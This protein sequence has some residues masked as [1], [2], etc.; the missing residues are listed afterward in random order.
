M[1]NVWLVAFVARVFVFVQ[2]SGGWTPARGVA[3]LKGYLLPLISF[4]AIAFVLRDTSFRDARILESNEVEPT[5]TF[6][7]IRAETLDTWK[8]NAF[9]VYNDL[10]SLGLTAILYAAVH[11]L[12]QLVRRCAAKSAKAAVASTKDS[13]FTSTSD[14]PY[15]A[16]FLWDPSCLVVAW[17][18][19]LFD[20]VAGALAVRGGAATKGPASV[21]E[22][23]SVKATNDLD[24]RYVLMNIAFLSD[25]WNWLAMRFGH[26]RIHL[27]ELKEMDRKILHSY[28]RAR[29]IREYEIKQEDIT[30]LGSFNVS[31]LAW[32]Q[33][34]TCR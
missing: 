5:A 27:F 32:E 3:G 17:N 12:G 26:T 19:D 24:S 11:A 7:Y 8:M 9:G 14:V 10:L 4:V 15:S 1:R 34:I 33:V 25:P 30:L 18:N 2:T 31:D 29:F 22:V 21:L 16:G 20:W 23:P 6:M 28:S 13:M